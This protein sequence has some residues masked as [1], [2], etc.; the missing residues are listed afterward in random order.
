MSPQ[1]CL[2]FGCTRSVEWSIEC[3]YTRRPAIDKRKAISF[4]NLFQ[5][6]EGLLEAANNRL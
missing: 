3:T 2:S 4:P 1:F 6:E 5:K